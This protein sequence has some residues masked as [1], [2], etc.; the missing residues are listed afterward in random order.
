MELSINWLKWIIIIVSLTMG[1]SPGVGEDK[2]IAPIFEKDV[3]VIDEEQKIWIEPEIIELTPELMK[4]W[5]L[6]EEAKEAIQGLFK[7]TMELEEKEDEVLLNFSFEN[8]SKEEQALYFNS[9]QKFDIFI[10]NKAGDEVY[11]YSEHYGFTQALIDVT[12]QPEEVLDFSYPWNYQDDEGNPVPA[13]EYTITVWVTINGKHSR[14]HP[15]DKTAKKTYYYQ[16]DDRE[17]HSSRSI[18]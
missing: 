14:I 1:L 5:G 17:I 12:L 18:R 16:L 9:G 7:T 15:Q 8:L 6:E 2:N 10:H 4:K 13:G 11:H 3:I